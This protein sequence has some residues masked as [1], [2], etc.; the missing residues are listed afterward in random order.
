MFLIIIPWRFS[1]TCIND[2]TFKYEPQHGKTNKMICV[3]S[4][5]SDQPG[6][7]PSLI[8][9]RCLHEETL[10]PWLSLECTVKTLIRLGGCPCW[11]VFAGRL[12]IVLVLSSCA[13]AHVLYYHATP[14]HNDPLFVCLICGF[15]SQS[16]TMVMSRRSVNLT[17]ILFLGRLPKL[18]TSTKCPSFRQ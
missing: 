15:T 7:L 9:L 6:H 10:G 18:L 8:S 16:T 14:Y 17:T 1:N 5:D 13:V 3:P 11:S 12:V 4:K 2:C